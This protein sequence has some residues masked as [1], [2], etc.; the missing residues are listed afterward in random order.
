MTEGQIVSVF[1]D[2]EQCEKFKALV[3]LL[4]KIRDGYPFILNDAYTLINKE[5]VA[6]PEDKLEVFTYERWAVEVIDNPLN[7]DCYYPIGS[8]FQQ[9]I[10][11]LYKKSPKEQVDE[12][13]NNSF[14]DL[15]DEFNNLF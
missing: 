14:E 5:V 9:N 4:Y 12:I 1:W 8:K 2:Y 3:K 13:K 6:I 11:V 10:R 15:K 7:K